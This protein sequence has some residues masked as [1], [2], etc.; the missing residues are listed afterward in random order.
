MPNKT[1]LP[2]TVHAMDPQLAQWVGQTSERLKEVVRKAQIN[3]GRI[4][5]LQTALNLRDVEIAKL[6]ADGAD[7]DERIEDLEGTVSGFQKM[8]NHLAI[9]LLL[10]GIGGGSAIPFL[11]YL[12]GLL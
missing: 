6:K 4:G 12:K 1:P 3:H 2:N 10:A 11:Q 9:K 7:K 5:E 8:I